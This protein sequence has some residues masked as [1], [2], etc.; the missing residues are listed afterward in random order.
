MRNEGGPKR[1]AQNEGSK[2]G[3]SRDEVEWGMKDGGL[4]FLIS[5]NDSATTHWSGRMTRAPEGGHAT[6][7]PILMCQARCAQG[8]GART[9]AIAAFAEQSQG[10]RLAETSL[11]TWPAAR[12]PD[13]SVHSSSALVGVEQLPEGT[14]AWAAVTPPRDGGPFDLWSKRQALLADLITSSKLCHAVTCHELLVGHFLKVRWQSFG[15]SRR[16]ALCGRAWPGFPL[17]RV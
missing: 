11:A 8:F 10:N 2:E 17:Q 4:R 9:C 5:G 13:A 15:R 16:A 7:F 6:H 14:E 3:Q 12:T 1:S